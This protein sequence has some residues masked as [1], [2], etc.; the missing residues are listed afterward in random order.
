MALHLR[1]HDVPA[2][3]GGIYTR[4]LCRNPREHLH[5]ASRIWTRWLHR[6]TAPK[7]RANPQ[8]QPAEADFRNAPNRPIIQHPLH[9]MSLSLCE[10]TYQRASIFTTALACPTETHRR[11]RYPTI[12]RNKPSSFSST[13]PAATLPHSPGIPSSTALP[14]ALLPLAPAPVFVS[15][16]D[17]GSSAQCRH[18]G[19]R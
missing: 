1:L 17:C 12:F 3:N 7:K 4:Y 9:A 14:P 11:H 16:R 2:L 10:R 8:A 6:R 18:N 19:G 5:A 15:S 13:K